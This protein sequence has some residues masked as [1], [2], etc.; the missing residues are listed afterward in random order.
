M[1]QQGNIIKSEV[2]SVALKKVAKF[3]RGVPDG[4]GH[5]LGVVRPD[6]PGGRI[7]VHRW[8]T[9]LTLGPFREL[10]RPKCGQR[11]AGA[12][13]QTP[14]RLPDPLGRATAFTHS[15]PN[16][17][18]GNIG[19][20]GAFGATRLRQRPQPQRSFARPVVAWLDS[21]CV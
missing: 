21:C 11:D 2:D 5:H 1:S 19:P 13:R 9:F 12:V 14:G 16:A 8:T 6:P 4:C 17:Q 18:T 15:N 3:L 10:L 20:S 7:M